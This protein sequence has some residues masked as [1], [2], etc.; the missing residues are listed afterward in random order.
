[1]VESKSPSP[2]Q[3]KNNSTNGITNVIIPQDK[4]APVNK[5]MIISAGKVNNKLTQLDITLDSGN[6]Y[7]GM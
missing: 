3:K 5:I 1:M 7:F 6:R 4:G 2:R